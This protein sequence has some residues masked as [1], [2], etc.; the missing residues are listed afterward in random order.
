MLM[1]YA[2]TIQLRH[3]WCRR[4]TQKCVERMWGFVNIDILET[5]ITDGNK[6]ISVNV[7]D[8]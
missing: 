8:V 6:G 7:F 5:E 2:L 1:D 4:Y 3:I